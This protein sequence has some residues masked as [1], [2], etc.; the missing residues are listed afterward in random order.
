MQY[1]VF[2]SYSRRDSKL[3]EKVCESLTAAGISFFI[4][5]EGIS[6]GANFPEV[7][8]RTIDSATIFLLIAGENAYKSKFTKAEILYAFNHKRSGCIIPYIIDDTPMPSDLE[9]LLGNVNWV[10]ASKCPVADLP[11]EVKKALDNPDQGTIGGR[12]VKKMWWLWLLIPIVLGVAGYVAYSSMQDYKEDKQAEAEKAQ[13]DADHGCY[14]ELI[15]QSDSLVAAA[16]VL[17]RRD[18]TLETTS[19]QIADLQQAADLLAQSDSVKALHDS[20]VLYRTLFNTDITARQNIIRERLDSM[21]K[22]WSEY[23]LDS[24]SLYQVTGSKSEAQNTLDCIEH[25]L[26]IKPSPE[27]QTIK[28]KLAK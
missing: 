8:A 19:E 16:S 22:A 27:L 15:R 1:D 17:S 25:A 10:Y 28:N 7:L 4:D 18:N 24:W 9:F 21:H 3:V 5:K 13:A 26:S 20:Q 23:A 6:A 14:R 12:K 2:I 11:V